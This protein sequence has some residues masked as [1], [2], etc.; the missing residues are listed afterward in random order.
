MSLEVFMGPSVAH[1]SRGQ[2]STSATQALSGGACATDEIV[3][4]DLVGL[5]HSVD[6]T[7][8]VP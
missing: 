2:E 5:T 8:I 3:G 1:K 7:S 6:V 4:G